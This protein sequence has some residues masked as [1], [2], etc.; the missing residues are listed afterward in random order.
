MQIPEQEVS[1]GAVTW[2]GVGGFLTAN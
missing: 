2:L 1:A